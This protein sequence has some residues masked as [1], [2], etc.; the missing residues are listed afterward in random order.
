MSSS[1]SS[2]PLTTRDFWMQYWSQTQPESVS[3]DVLFKDL[4]HFFPKAP[5]RFIEIGGFPGIFSTYFKKYLKYDVTLLDFVV[6]KDILEKIQEVNGL[7][8]GEI[9]AIEGDLFQ[10][11]LPEKKFD[12]VFSAGFI[13]HFKDTSA[14]FHK[15]VEYMNDDGI[16]YI[17]LP[18]FKG[19][20]GLVQKWL[21]ID[22]Y[23]VHNIDCMEKFVLQ[24]LALAY[25]LEIKFLD[26]WGIPHLWLDHPDLV[27]LFTRKLVYLTS[28]VL[29]RTGS[30]LKGRYFSPCIVLIAKKKKIGDVL[31]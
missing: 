15:H 24:K 18:N 22:N 1:D 6:A 16:L 10:L 31:V 7:M 19:I 23:N 20:N 13:E 11:P 4:L 25:N 30:L 8:P 29:S 12:V 21:D 26:Y 2:L 27:S 14:V 17:S 3:E 5:A 9:Q 28:A